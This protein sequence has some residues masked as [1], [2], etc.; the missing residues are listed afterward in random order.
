MLYL[1]THVIYT[2]R[3]TWTTRL[4]KCSTVYAC[5]LFVFIRR[6]PFIYKRIN[7]HSVYYAL[8]AFQLV[9]TSILHQLSTKFSSLL[10]HSSSRPFFNSQKGPVYLRDVRAF[11]KT[12]RNPLRENFILN[13][14]S[15]LRYFKVKVERR[16]FV[17]VKRVVSE[18]PRPRHARTY[19][20]NTEAKTAHALRPPNSSSI[21]R[22]TKTN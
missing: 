1:I 6:C 19:N 4:L 7:D 16:A 2:R 5:L 17:I 13:A 3:R 8:D 15:I 22:G 9:P 21:P 10:L 18:I 20:T 14:H 11:F 12:A